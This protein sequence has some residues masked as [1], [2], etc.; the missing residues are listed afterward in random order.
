MRPIVPRNL[1]LS[2]SNFLTPTTSTSQGQWLEQER[3]QNIEDHSDQI[4]PLILY[5]R[6][7]NHDWSIWTSLVGQWEDGK[8]GCKQTNQQKIIDIV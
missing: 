8:K 5:E 6:P 1:M 7:H 4:T 3:Y 2:P